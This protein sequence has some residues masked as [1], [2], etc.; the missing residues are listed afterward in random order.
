MP[1]ISYGIYEGKCYIYAVHGS[2]GSL[3]SPY[4]KKINR[5]LYKANSDLESTDDEENIKDVTLS[6]IFALTI[7]FKMLSDNNIKD[8]VVKNFYPVRANNKEIV[9]SNKINKLK[10]MEL[11]SDHPKYIDWKK[12]MEELSSEVDRIQNNIINK[13]LRNFMRLEY[14]FSNINITSYP[15]ELDNCMHIKLDEYKD[16]DSDHILNQVYENVEFS[17][18]HKK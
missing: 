12:T 9:I 5:L 13:Y 10:S 18:K 17:K 7:F 15:Y 4:E 1:N 3:N 6:H 14:H 2:R 16:F 8:V 11:S